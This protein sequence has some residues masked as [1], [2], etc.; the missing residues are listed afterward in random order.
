[1]VFPTKYGGFA[2][3]MLVYQELFFWGEFSHRA[4]R[5][6]TF[7]CHKPMWVSSHTSTISSCLWSPKKHICFVSSCSVLKPRDEMGPTAIGAVGQIL[8][9]SRFDEAVCATR[10]DGF[11]ASGESSKR[12]LHLL[13]SFDS[14]GTG[15]ILNVQVEWVMRRIG[16]I[17]G[18]FR[19]ATTWVS[20]TG[21]LLSFRGPRPLVNVER[22]PRSLGPEIER[23][24]PM[25]RRGPSTIPLKKAL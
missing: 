11:E 24:V 15:G 1:M 5:G 22:G 4:W 25:A 21:Y 12:P 18:R 19:T 16:A 13:F 8:C 2:I 3:V 9:Y 17:P 6:L 10:C 23:H 20:T 14:N 7:R